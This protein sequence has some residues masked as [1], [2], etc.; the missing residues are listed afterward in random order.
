MDKLEFF[1][2]IPALKNFS[3]DFISKLVQIAEEGHAKG[4]EI[5]FR[6]LDPSEYLYIIFQG[7]VIITKKIAPEIEKILSILKE[8]D[9]FGEMS[10]FTDKP[11]TATAKAKN[12]LTYYKVHSESFR[13]L[14]SLD[15][16]GTQKMLESLLLSA[17]ERLE[18]TSRE[19]ATVYEI[20]KIIVKNL[21]MNEF[22]DLVIKQLCYSI[23]E[24][25]EGLF[26]VW[27][28]FTED[29]ESSKISIPKN[30]K[31]I[32]FLSDKTETTPLDKTEII[33]A[34][35]YLITPL[36]KEKLIGFILFANTE[37]EVTFSQGTKDLLNSVALQLIGAIENIKN[38]QEKY[39]R[40]RFDRTRSRTITW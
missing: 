21:P 27:N 37:K 31:I 1:K 8:K 7:E 28:E 5:I 17:L 12:D 24:I 38:Q 35:S 25:D 32:E 23:P 3:K 30:H 14:F 9:I 13:K 4:G 29:Y 22:C 2:S 6:E 39:D 26:F 18:H 20:S 16:T 10:L 33:P 19:L 11:R 15:P 40:E 36:I 34:K